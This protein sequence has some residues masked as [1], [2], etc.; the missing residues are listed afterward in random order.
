MWLTLR[1][2]THKNY[3]AETLAKNNKLQNYFCI[4]VVVDDT[5]LSNK[6]N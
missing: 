6:L 3:S 2:F 1:Y 4:P 5:T